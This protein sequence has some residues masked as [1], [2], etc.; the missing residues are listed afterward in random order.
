MCAYLQW[1]D[2]V[3]I[4]APYAITEEM[5]QSLRISVVVCGTVAPSRRRGGNSQG[6]CTSSD[7]SDNDDS[8]GYGRMSGAQRHTV[9]K[10][11]TGRELGEGVSKA[12]G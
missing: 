1:V 5:I 2:D 3:L 6:M 11:A 9:N 10:R 7:S 8:S 4:D 12:L